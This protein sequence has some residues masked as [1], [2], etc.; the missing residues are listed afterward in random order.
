MALPKN[1]GVCLQSDSNYDADSEI[2]DT[3]VGRTKHRLIKKGRKC[4]NQDGLTDQ[5]EQSTDQSWT[6]DQEQTDSQTG[7][8]NQ[9][10]NIST[11]NSSPSESETSQVFLKTR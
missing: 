8:S 2:I 6:V 7:H 5:T 3:H 11:N 1:T 9:A 4:R 10:S